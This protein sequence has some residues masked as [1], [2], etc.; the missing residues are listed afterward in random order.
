MKI[1]GR[2][3]IFIL[4]LIAIQTACKLMFSPRLEWSGFSPLIAIAL[5]SGF[6]IKQRT[7]SFLLP[8]V[9]LFISDV[10]IHL[11]YLNGQFD[12]VG[13]YPGQWKNY[14][15]L[16]LCTALGWLLKGRTY[17]SLAISAVGAPTVY[18]LASNFIVW[19]GASEAV[20]ARSF[21]GLMNCYEAALPF[22]RNSV[23]ATLVF[24]PV[25]LLL[26]NYLTRR[27]LVL[28]VA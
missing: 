22:Y 3:I 27:K 26:Y 13:L 2:F 11:L 14:L 16:L 12:F 15:I 8:L 17:T 18:F 1:N 24:L 28:T 20:Y 6:I 4:I 5:V 9:A 19:Q 7:L 23:I 21:S 25:I 10:I